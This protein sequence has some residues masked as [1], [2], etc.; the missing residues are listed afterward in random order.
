MHAMDLRGLDHID[1]PV[2]VVVGARDRLTHPKLG[3][4]IAQRIDAKLVEIDDAGHM[5]PFEAPG[6]LADAIAEHV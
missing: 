2:T 5:L 1:V 3:R 6:A 4:E